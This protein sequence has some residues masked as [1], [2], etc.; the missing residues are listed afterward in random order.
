MQSTQPS[1]T[2]DT[3]LAVLVML[4]RYHQVAVDSSQL[5]HHFGTHEKPFE[6][7]EIIRA[8]RHLN[9]KCRAL[10]ASWDK[11][12]SISLPAIA[13]TNDGNYVVLAKA[14]QDEVLIQD[15]LSNAPETLSKEQFEER[16]NGALVLV[17]KRS[18]LPGGNDKFDISWFIPA[19]LKYKH[20]LRDVIVASFFIQLFALITVLA[21][22][23]PWIKYEIFN[24][25]CT[26]AWD[27][28][29]R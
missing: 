6:Q 16:W 24:F 26:F 10:R 12:G 3:G 22:P 9:L 23:I 20:L 5:R 2:V 14:S 18:L 19:I 29:L 13:E 8:A 1:G 27:R 4:A 11:L 7:S 25:I 17:S 15:P 21:F 28:W